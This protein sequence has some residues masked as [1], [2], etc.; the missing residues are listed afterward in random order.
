MI[1][2]TQICMVIIN[3]N[4]MFMENIM[5]FILL[6]PSVLEIVMNRTLQPRRSRWMERREIL[7]TPK[8]V[9]RRQDIE[10][11]KD[12]YTNFIFSGEHSNATVIVPLT[13]PMQKNCVSVWLPVLK[14][15]VV[16]F[17]KK[18]LPGLFQPIER[19]SNELNISWIKVWVQIE[20]NFMDSNVYCEYIVCIS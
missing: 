12:G 8:R 4:I 20:N 6:Q 15:G 18:W 1:E 13:K 7:W 19:R 14:V 9:A 10:S 3:V 5:I 16:F 17:A 11:Q 2:F